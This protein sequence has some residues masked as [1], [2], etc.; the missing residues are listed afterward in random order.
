MFHL[1]RKIILECDIKFFF[2]ESVILAMK[3]GYNTIFQSVESDEE[4]LDKEW[5]SI[6]W[7]SIGYVIFKI[8]RRIFEA[9][10]VGD[11]R[12]VNRLCSC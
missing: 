10:K 8:Q 6:N 3:T 5:K 9:E 4:V 11:Y 7:K 2:Y 1:K 12:K